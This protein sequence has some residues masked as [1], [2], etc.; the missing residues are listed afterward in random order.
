MGNVITLVGES[1]VCQVQLFEWKLVW[2]G[3]KVLFSNGQ[4]VMM[5]KYVRRRSS[6]IEVAGERSC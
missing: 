1:R 2:K 3:E 4:I 6:P 5:P